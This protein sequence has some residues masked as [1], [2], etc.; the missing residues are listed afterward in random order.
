[1]RLFKYIAWNAALYTMAYAAT[2]GNVNVGRV[3]VAV[4]WLEAII[5]GVAVI[6]DLE[7]TPQR[8]AKKT[9]A[10][11]NPSN[12]MRP[13]VSGAMALFLVWSGWW[14]TALAVFLKPW[15]LAVLLHD[16]SK[17]NP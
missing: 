10:R 5:C 1:M 13:Y 12:R 3:L 15:F 6:G 4:V 14:F 2:S 16:K 17:L 8:E 7:S 9:K 11:R